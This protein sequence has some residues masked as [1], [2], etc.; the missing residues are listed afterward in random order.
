MEPLKI[1][2]HLLVGKF[3]FLI[4]LDF[5]EVIFVFMLNLFQLLQNY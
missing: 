1:I 3:N 4:L 2:S 5:F